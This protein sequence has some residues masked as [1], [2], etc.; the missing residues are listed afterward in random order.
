[1]G[2]IAI[3]R[4]VYTKFQWV[5]GEF[6]VGRSKWGVY[7]VKMRNS[8]AVDKWG[9]DLVPH[10]PA[11]QRVEVG[12]YEMKKKMNW[13][14][15]GVKTRRYGEVKPRGETSSLLSPQTHPKIG[16]HFKQDNWGEK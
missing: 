13:G 14:D 15:Y 8:K 4:E 11:Q 9:V 7:G 1:M 10:D 5:R 3:K 2:R 12:E 6:E 16:Q